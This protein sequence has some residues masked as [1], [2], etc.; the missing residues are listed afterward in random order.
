[1]LA[2]KGGKIM[3]SNRGKRGFLKRIITGAIISFL[4]FA[5][6]IGLAICTGYGKEL[7][8][9]TGYLVLFIILWT[10]FGSLGYAVVSG[11]IDY[12]YTHYI[13][14]TTNP[15]S[16]FFWDRIIAPLIGI[17]GFNILGFSILGS[18]FEP[19]QKIIKALV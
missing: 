11:I 7:K 12:F 15:I 10:L 5:A 4:L 2:S 13:H 3:E 16:E 1:M 8:P 19:F 14:Y 18:V 6:F 17:V 9:Y